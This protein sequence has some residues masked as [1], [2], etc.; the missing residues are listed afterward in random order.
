MSVKPV[1]DEVVK[2]FNE[3][4]EKDAALRKELEGVNK[5]IQVDLGCEQYC[6]TLNAC[7]VD[8]LNEGTIECPDVII[9]SDPDTVMKLRSGEIKPMKAWALKKLRVKGSI[10]DVLRLRKFF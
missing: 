10:E 1:L 9:I 4:V 7:K 3:K 5:K 2:K 8:K 6:F